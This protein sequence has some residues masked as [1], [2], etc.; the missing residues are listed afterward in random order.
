MDF[1]RRLNGL[2]RKMT[3]LGLDLVVY[4][5]SPDLRYLTGLAFCRQADAAEG[6][7]PV[8]LFVPQE[9]EPVLVATGTLADRAGQSWIGDVRI[10]R[11]ENGRA[12]LVEGVLRDLGVKGGRI[13]LGQR[14]AEPVKRAIEQA[15]AGAELCGA[16]GLMDHLR[17]V[18]EPGEI[19]RLRRVAGITGRALEAVVP[20]IKE[21]VTQPE[22][23][24]EVA[25]QGRRLGA[26]G[27]SFEPAAKFVRRGSE[28][29]SDPFTYPKEKG[30]VPGTSIAFDM[31]FVMDGYCSDF[32]RSFYFGPADEEAR[33][34]Y[35][36]LHEALI[37]TVSGMRDGGMGMSDLFPLLEKALDRLGY[38][39]YLRA[40]LP[41]GVLGHSIGVEVHE[42]PWMRPGSDEPLRAGMVLALEPKL[43]HAGRYYL[44]VEDMVLVGAEESEILTSFDR[45]L[46]EL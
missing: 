2:R 11:E 19:K 22:L 12:R 18:K 8:G 31:G 20:R 33:G 13:A 5:A 36:A 45:E 34:G 16:R 44:R 25:L 6:S 9:G 41:N 37:E 32:G 39:D 43:W 38:G 28:V 14:V 46:F 35:A 10:H 1:E 23:E 3:G 29:S 24:E 4:G 17:M 26:S 30:L 27:V 15:A 42:N 40:R 7:A 21:G